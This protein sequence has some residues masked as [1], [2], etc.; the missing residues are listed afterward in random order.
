[1]RNLILTC[2][3]GIQAFLFCEVP[4]GMSPTQAT[5]WENVETMINEATDGCGLPVDE[6]IKKPVIALNALNFE[7]VQSCE[8]H[9]DG[10]L[11]YPW[12]SLRPDK[13]IETLTI[14]LYQKKDALCAEETVMENERIAAIQTHSHTMYDIEEMAIKI[15]RKRQ[16]IW[17]TW[18]EIEQA[19]SKRFDDIWTLLKEFYGDEISVHQTTLII[20]EDRLIPIGGL[21]Q[22]R[23]SKEKQEE[24]LKAFQD[25]MNRFAEFL[26]GKF[27]MTQ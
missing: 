8:G 20:H 1:M 6:G 19:E 16:D 7:T 5:H 26:I 18:E 25:E 9:L 4:A 10:G 12:I 17:K 14:N 11:P 24:N 3:F 27:R 15:A 23:F 2:I 21:C 13:N 22:K